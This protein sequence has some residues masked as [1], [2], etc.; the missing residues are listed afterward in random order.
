MLAAL[1][2]EKYIV[3][4]KTKLI[5]FPSIPGITEHF[6][7]NG[8]LYYKLIEFQECVKVFSKYIFLVPL[9]T[10]VP[11]VSLESAHLVRAAMWAYD[12]RTHVL[13]SCLCLQQC[14]K[15]IQGCYQNVRI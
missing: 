8:D 1:T 13:T 11:Q 15:E 5:S 6:I 3:Q 12:E 7:L 9:K 2:G 4:S 14:L 10:S